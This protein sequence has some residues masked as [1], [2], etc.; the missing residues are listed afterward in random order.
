MSNQEPAY[1]Q[2]FDEIQAGSYEDIEGTAMERTSIEEGIIDEPEPRNGD[3][4][5]YVPGKG[6]CGLW[7]PQNRPGTFRFAPIFVMPEHRGKKIG[8]A[9]VMYRYEFAMARPDID[10]LDTYAHNPE[11]F[12]KL[13]FEEENSYQMGTHYLTYEKD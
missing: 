3:V 4:W 6:F 8:K 5:F 2:W 1:E 9:F 13:G 10:R 11:L 12:L 7:Q